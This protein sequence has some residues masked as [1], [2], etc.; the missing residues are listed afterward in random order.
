M[1]GR[2]LFLFLYSAS[3][4]A[5]LVYEIAWTRLLTL[6]MGQTVAAASTAL[7]AIMGGLALGSWIG[8]GV[9]A[10]WTAAD[11]HRRALS[12]YAAL[13]IFVAVTAL[14]LP[15]LLAAAAPA[16]AWAYGDGHAGVR[17]GMMRA[18][19]AL[20]LVGIP[21]TAMGATFPIA[22]A[23]S[24]RS[25][26]DAGLLYAF[27][28][29]GAAIGSILTGFVLLP[30]AGIR[31]TTWAGVALN[32]V[33]AA[34]AQWLARRPA[35]LPVEEPAARV[36]PAAR[37]KARRS[38][39]PPVRAAAP[40]L[41]PAPRLAAA[42]AA[43]SGFC[44]LVY[45][46]IW[47][48]L[49]ALVI[50]P[51][52]YAFAT[53]VAS[54]IVGL[55]VGS[56][57]AARWLP[58]IR[59]P[60]AWLGATLAVAAVGASAAGWFAASR[61]P[62][63]VAGQVAAPDAAFASIVTRQAIGTAL[64]L[65]PMTLALGAAFPLALATASSTAADVGGVSARVYGAN[66]VGAIAGSLVGGFV[67]LPALGLQTSLRVTATLG[68]V[69]AA[70]VW[71][72]DSV[73]SERR[74]RA[75]TW[76]GAMIAA[77]TIV[78]IVLPAW[79]PQLLAGGA[80]KYAPYL[81]VTDLENDLLTWK[82]EYLEDGPT[83]TVSVRELAGQRSLVING[84]VDASNMGDMLTQRLLG[85]LPVLMHAHA[86]RVLVL[87]LGSGVT[88]A[89]VLAPGT[90]RALDVVEISPEVVKASEFFR[91]ENGDVL[92]RPGVNLIV[93]DGRSHLALGREQYDVIVSE[94]SNPWMAGIAALFTREFFATARARLRPDGIVCQ[95]AHTYDISAGDLKSIVRTFTAVFPESTMWLVGD[96]DLLLIGTNGPSIESHLD[97]FAA[98]ARQ[99][100]TASL[101]RD[102]DVRE[103]YVPFLLMSL[104][105]GGPSQMQAYG[106]DAALQSD[107]AMALEFSGPRAIYG[108]S[109]ADNAVMHWPPSAA[110]A[111]LD[112]ISKA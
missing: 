41:A 100:A 64:L 111:R 94:P 13:E 24:A 62:L 20:L 6:L 59:R 107:D 70:A 101:L 19:L 43:A 84:K 108:R 23:A 50:G 86:E 49:A 48:R 67:L 30:A 85:L 31:M 40:L 28:T 46:V 91:K 92:H 77:A 96:G 16:L 21:A 3:G 51:T 7:A 72:A 71:A 75:W 45:E 4:A 109:N 93:G 39:A 97:G 102:V 58:R 42:A 35:A 104:L 87:G 80:Y 55:A 61:L 25:A 29:A 69:A 112:G 9:Q 11:K 22:V 57:V 8:G 98:R 32:V 106:G 33:A 74:A 83:A 44:A 2:R 38:K 76:R 66:T 95:W 60:A 12:T 34:G 68:L 79:S 89:S 63:V 73:G 17:F 15:L 99:G 14:A 5:A 53:V 78:L 10:R 26:S 37:Q 88:A 56:A 36:V 90:T 52:T 103:R 47:T 54:F 81:G 65:L 1:R 105:A 27:N 18:A 82:L 110:A